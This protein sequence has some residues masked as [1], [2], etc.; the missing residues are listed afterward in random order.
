MIGINSVWLPRPPAP[1]IVAG[2][3]PQV[4]GWA[5]ADI[6]AAIAALAP[7]A[8]GVLVNPMTLRGQIIYAS[9][10][11]TPSPPAALS[12]GVA[13]TFLR[14]NGPGADPSYEAVASADAL[15]QV[16]GATWGW[17][18]PV[19]SATNITGYGALACITPTATD[20]TS[21]LQSGSTYGTP[22]FYQDTSSVLNNT[23]VLAYLLS[24]GAAMPPGL[25]GTGGPVWQ[26]TFLVDQTTVYLAVNF[27]RGQPS[28][29]TTATE[30]GNCAGVSF[31]SGDTTF[32][33]FCKGSSTERRD[34]GV[35]LVAGR[36]YSVVVSYADFPTTTRVALWDWSTGTWVADETFN[37]APAP[38]VAGFAAIYQ[39][40]TTAAAARIRHYGIGVTRAGGPVTLP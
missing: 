32:H 25:I 40:T 11:G 28:L 16:P 27:G 23:T 22:Y 12:P 15:T 29:G 4:Y 21:G 17:A 1:V 7:L 3:S 35:A 31:L 37:D 30:H 39:Q 26:T 6:A 8:P 24:A 9:A 2:T 10:D 20:A 34:T 19:A 36:I 38:N 18:G 13:G 14:S 33:A 5:P